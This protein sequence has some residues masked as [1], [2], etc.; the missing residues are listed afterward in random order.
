MCVTVYIVYTYYIPKSSHIQH[1]RQRPVFNKKASFTYKTNNLRSGDFFLCM[2]VSPNI[3]ILLLKKEYTSLRPEKKSKRK[4]KT[5]H[6]IKSISFYSMC[7]S[8]QSYTLLIYKLFNVHK[9]H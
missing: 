5:V 4:K 2:Y 7:P 1:R 8:H 3:I 6:Q 9:N